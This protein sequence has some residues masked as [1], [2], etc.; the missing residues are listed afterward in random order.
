M[1]VILLML[2]LAVSGGLFTGIV[3]FSAVKTA[4]YDQLIDRAD[5]M[6]RHAVP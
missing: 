3:L 6:L 5:K 4:R 1:L 2:I